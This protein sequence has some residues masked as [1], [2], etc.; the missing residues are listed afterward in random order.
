MEWFQSSRLERAWELQQRSDGV[1]SFSAGEVAGQVGAGDTGEAAIST[2]IVERLFAPDR[3]Y[4]VTHLRGDTVVSFLSYHWLILPRGSTVGRA[5]PVGTPV[6]VE[7]DGVLA[8]IA[9]DDTAVSGMVGDESMSGERGVARS[10]PSP[11][12]EQRCRNS[13]CSGCSGGR[14]RCI[15][16][17]GGK[18]LRDYP[19]AWTHHVDRRRKRASADGTFLI[20]RTAEH[21]NLATSCRFWYL[22]AL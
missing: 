19:R 15:G 21:V 4:S 20:V 17:P 22:L 7:R 14:N 1:Y 11:E 3:T 13:G 2:V 18:P 5:G 6:Y 16:R 10:R 8:A 9:R 12:A